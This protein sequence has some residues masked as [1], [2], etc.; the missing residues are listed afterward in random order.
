MII[1]DDSIDLLYQNHSS[2]QQVVRTE[3]VDHSNFVLNSKEIQNK[4]DK[5]K[6]TFIMDT[7]VSLSG[8]SF[9]TEN[10]VSAVL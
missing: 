7:V 1:K 4:I 6:K 3:Q 2:T 10:S 9:F 8:G 5:N